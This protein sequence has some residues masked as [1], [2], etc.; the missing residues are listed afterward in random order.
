M[1]TRTALKIF[2]FS[3]FAIICFT[4][5]Y[6]IMRSF[7]EN[8]QVIDMY[9]LSPDLVKILP[10]VTICNNNR[11]SL[12][13]LVVRN[14][15]IRQAMKEKFPAYVEK[16]APVTSKEFTIFRDGVAKIFDR[17]KYS[18][19]DE[20]DEA[21]MNDLFALK[22]DSKP[23]LTWLGCARTYSNSID[24]EH[25]SQIDSVQDR[26]CV[27]ILHKGA[28]NYDRNNKPELFNSSRVSSE[29]HS[30]FNAKEVVKMIVNFEP[31]DYADLKR[32]IGSRIIFHGN[33][34]VASSSDPD[35]FVARGYKYDFNIDRE[36]L[37]I[38]ETACTNYE[39]NNIETFQ[40][41]I[42]P[43]RPL[44]GDT[45]FQNCVVRNIIHRSNCWP[46]TMPYY[47]NDS[48]DPELNLKSCGW[49]REPPYFSIYRE[50]LRVEKLKEDMKNNNFTSETPP[51]TTESGS[52][53]GSSIS[54]EEMRAYM[55]VRKH[56]WSQCASS[57]TL[58]K[59]SVTVTRTVWPSDVGLLFDESG[60]NQVLRHCCAL[61]SIKYSHFHYNVHEFTPKYNIVDTLGNVGGLLAVWLNLSIISVYHAIQKLISLFQ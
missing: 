43:R 25:L 52:I 23:Y 50:L 31:E 58:T 1:N 28:M 54:K 53:L 9:D 57:C 18:P 12:K 61:I 51:T 44:Y 41:R 5:V 3:L 39:K 46:T 11:L 15:T 33:N 21:T 36:D 7:L 55:K 32:Q 47:R 29:R 26:R 4:Q 42:D 16:Q 22:P 19:Q 10:G 24:C 60:R 40:Q 13:K 38:Q 56:C 27:T 37:I 34:Y 6:M 8:P 17:L 45:C 59:Y 30:Y 2:F 48:Y 49:F 20:M 14:Q 35:F